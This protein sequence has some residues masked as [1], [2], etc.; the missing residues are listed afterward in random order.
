M[1]ETVGE[2][3]VEVANG[4]VFAY[5]ITTTPEPPLRSIPAPLPTAPPAPPPVLAVPSVPFT[6]VLLLPP[7]PPPPAPPAPPPFPP[8]PPNADD[9]TETG[10]NITE[11]GNPWE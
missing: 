11:D 4:N 6:L 7:F 8:F 1:F 9:D 10:A 3:V 2:P 5:R